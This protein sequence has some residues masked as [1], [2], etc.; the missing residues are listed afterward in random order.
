MLDK[1]KNKIDKI[2]RTI[3]NDLF[4]MELFFFIGLFIITYTNFCI[5]KY[6]GLYFM[7]IMFIVYAI[8]LNKFSTTKKR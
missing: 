6:F 5:N 8:F 4:I 7:G 3:L 2:K 1:F